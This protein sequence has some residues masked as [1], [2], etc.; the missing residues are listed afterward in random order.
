MNKTTTTRAAA[1]LAAATLTTGAASTASAEDYIWNVAE[2]V[3][4]TIDAVAVAN[5]G[6]KDLVKTGRGKLISS[7]AMAS[8]TG[9]ITVREGAFEITTTGD[10]GTDAGGTFVENGGTLVV[11]MNG[12]SDSF[13][14]ANEEVTIAGTGD[15]AYGAAV[16]QDSRWNSQFKIFAKLALSG[17][18]T[19][20]AGKRLGLDAGALTMNGYTL[21]LKGENFTFR[22]LSTPGTV[23]NI[24]SEAAL[25]SI[26]AGSYV[27]GDNS[28]TL[29]L[30]NGATLKIGDPSTSAV[31]GINWKLVV[32]TGA[33]VT[34][35][36]SHNRVYYGDVEW[37]STVV[38]GASGPLAFNG[39]VTG[40]GTIKSSSATL[41]FAQPLGASLGLDLSGTATATLAPAA[42]YPYT[43]RGMK[44]VRRSGMTQ[45]LSLFSDSRNDVNREYCAFGPGP[46]LDRS[47]Y[48]EIDGQKSWCSHGYI[49]NR[50]STN[51][52]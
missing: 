39:Q 17:D 14:F 47:S 7:N 27:V 25:L 10:L 40:T 11:N 45:D 15:A 6:A 46:Q 5:I 4:E 38:D 44:L 43:H 8:Y 32:E 42:A 49:W 33:K 22:T 29:T 18:A 52:T 34:A 21:T 19:I 36:A 35:E 37:N 50:E 51:V 30:Q 31:P 13:R 3:T 23:G 1:M 2:G 9:T 26:Y 48:W 16:W 20:F 12:S 24:V 41:A 28:K